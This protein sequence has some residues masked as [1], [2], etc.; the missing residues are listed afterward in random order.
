M[1]HSSGVSA[2]C[3]KDFLEVSDKVSTVIVSLV[4]HICLPF[5]PL[6]FQCE[7][8]LK[9]MYGGVVFPMPPDDTLTAL[10]TTDLMDLSNS[11]V[12]QMEPEYLDVSRS[13]VDQ[14]PLVKVS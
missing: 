2:Q 9:E 13:D 7:E 12:V 6:L 1:L 11:A 10:V 14:G 8:E 4:L 5:S 3:V